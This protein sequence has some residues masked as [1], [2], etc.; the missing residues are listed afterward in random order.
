[1]KLD[2]LQSFY[3]T[4]EMIKLVAA[5]REAR[6][7]EYNNDFEILQKISSGEMMSFE[8]L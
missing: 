3:R 8:N 1:M 7:K 6:R 4:K 5:Q 2:A